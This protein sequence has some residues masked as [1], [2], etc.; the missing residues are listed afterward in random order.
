V[1]PLQKYPVWWELQK[2]RP[3][4]VAADALKFELK[5]MF[6]HSSLAGLGLSASSSLGTSS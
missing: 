2:D 4:D 1:T 3:Q 5:V 6:C